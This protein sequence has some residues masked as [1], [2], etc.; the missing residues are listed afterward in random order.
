MG[1]IT[2]KNINSDLFKIWTSEMA[3]ILGYIF[4]DSCIAFDKNRKKNPYTLNITSV[5]KKHLY[6]IRKAFGSTHKISKKNNG[7]K[8]IAFQFQV[9]NSILCKDLINLGIKPRKTYKIDTNINVPDKYFPDFTRGFFDGDGTVYIYKVN[10]TPQIKAGFLSTSLHFF[11]KFNDRLCKSLSIPKK[12]IH[13][14]NKAPNLKL[15]LYDIHL[16]ISDCE[17][18][19][20]F[21][22]QNN[23]SLYLSRKQRIFEKWQLIKKRQYFKHSYPSKIGWQLNKNRVRI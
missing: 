18:L 9:R 16:Y 10:K 1:R 13:L 5:D 7:R 17:K 20:A 19:A 23:H 14:K 8:R 12:S 11:E 6:K 21:M 2:I 4:A 3:Y 22:Y 15:A